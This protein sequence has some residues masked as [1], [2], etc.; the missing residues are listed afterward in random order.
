[1]AGG[2][3]PFGLGG[4]AAAGPAGPGLG[5]PPAQ[6]HGRMVAGQAPGLAE[7]LLQHGAVADLLDVARRTAGTVGAVG[8]RLQPFP[9]SGGPAFLA[10]VSV[11]VD[12][13]GKLAPADRLG[14]DLERRQL[15]RVRAALVVG[16]KAA[17][18]RAQLP[19]RGG[20][21]QWFAC[22]VAGLGLQRQ[23]QPQALRLLQRLLQRG[24]FL[25]QAQAV[26]VQRLVI[27]LRLV[28]QAQRQ[29]QRFQQ[30]GT[31]R[32][33]RRQRQ[34]PQVG[35]FLLGIAP[36]LIGLRVQRGQRAGRAVGQA[37]A[38]ALQI[39]RDPALLKPGQAAQ[40]PQQRVQ[41][42]LLRQRLRIGQGLDLAVQ[43]QA[44]VAHIHQ[45]QRQALASGVAQGLG[46]VVGSG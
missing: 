11:I 44:A 46:Q 40:F 24:F 25:H 39:A 4:Q 14:I 43:R 38:P 42:Q 3:F 22:G 17:I 36:E 13:F 21:R 18:S 32:L 5:F 27:V 31:H 37:T 33:G 1:M 16:H 12:E 23:G 26:E 45:R 9:A 34:R 28:Q 20:Q 8:M 6:V 29:F 10:V 2:V 30:V 15:D 7:A 41:A 35:R 19:A